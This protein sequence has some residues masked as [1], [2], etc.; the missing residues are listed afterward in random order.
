M[1]T[2][3]AA[4]LAAKFI[5]PIILVDLA[6]NGQ[7]LH[8]WS[9][10]GTF[11]WNG[12]SYAGVGDLG[13]AST[14][15][16]GVDVQAAGAS[17]TLSG[18]NHAYV[19]DAL[20]DIQLGAPATIWLGAVNKNTLQLVASPV[21]LFAGVV[22]A[23]SVRIGAEQGAN[24]EPATADI[25]IPLESLLATLSSGQQRKYSR[26]DQALKYPDDTAFVYVS[27]LNYM[28]LVWG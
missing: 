26:A 9:G 25:T 7:V 8:I 2:A 4:T 13:Q 21:V 15:Q 6:I 19:A 27:F 12:N 11:V 3:M 18:V 10:V 1:Q 22:D 16:E 5:F 28:A 23:P 14:P 20:S 17:L 24:G